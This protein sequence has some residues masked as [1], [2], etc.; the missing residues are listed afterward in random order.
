MTVLSL[1]AQYTLIG[2]LPFTQ[3]LVSIQAL[4]PKGAGPSA[5]V[6]V[7]TDEGG[8]SVNTHKI[9]NMEK[10]TGSIQPS[11]VPNRF[12]DEFPILLQ[13]LART[14]GTRGNNV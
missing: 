13:T 14:L 6:V 4:N 8:Q 3:Y 1:C 2:L 5:T 7:M 10:N 9:L 12:L 11:S